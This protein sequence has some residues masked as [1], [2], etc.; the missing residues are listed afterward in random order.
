M[1][2]QVQLDCPQALQIEVATD[3]DRFQI[4]HRMR[5]PRQM[6]LPCQMHLLYQVSW[7]CQMPVPLIFS[8][9]ID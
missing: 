4:S 9:P 6:R 3:F 5:P 1:H 8:G 2:L 7:Y